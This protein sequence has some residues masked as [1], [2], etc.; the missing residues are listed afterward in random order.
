M[1]RKFSEHTMVIERL[2]Q[3]IGQLLIKHDGK[4]KIATK[5]ALIKE[6]VVDFLS[7][8]GY[9]YNTEQQRYDTVFDIELHAATSF[10]EAMGQK[11]PPIFDQVLVIASDQWGSGDLL[12]SQ[13]L[14]ESALLAWFEKDPLPAKVV[15]L[16]SGVKLLLPQSR[17]LASF[18]RVAA[19]GTA[20]YASAS[21]LVQY[22]VLSPIDCVESKTI[23]QLVQMMK[24]TKNTITL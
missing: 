15:F 12:Y 6:Q 17:L 4:L 8:N 2:D 3:L 14:L 19:E 10:G 1:E 20:L 13:G 24:S 21:C 22:A 9:A 5:D 11:R 18:R 23:F 7:I 16:N